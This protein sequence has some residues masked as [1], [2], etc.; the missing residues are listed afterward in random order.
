MDIRERKPRFGRRLRGPGRLV[1]NQR[2]LDSHMGTLYQS[3]A[4]FEMLVRVASENKLPFRLSQESFTRAPF[5]PSL[6]GP[7]T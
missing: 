6:L 4:L 3:K 2:I 7:V 1:F 5:M